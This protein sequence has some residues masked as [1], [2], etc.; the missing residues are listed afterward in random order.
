MKLSQFTT[1]W[2]KIN[3][4]VEAEP[5]QDIEIPLHLAFKRLSQ[6]EFNDRTAPTSQESLKDFLAD[7][8]VNWRDVTAEDGTPLPFTPTNLTALLNI[9]G[10]ANVLFARYLVEMASLRQKN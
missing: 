7:V 5:D 8:I 4:L 9:S 10:L 2:R 3:F 6:D 1:F